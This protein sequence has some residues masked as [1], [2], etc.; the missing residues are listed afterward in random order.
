MSTFHVECLESL[1]RRGFLARAPEYRNA[2]DRLYIDLDDRVTRS[3]PESKDAFLAA[4]HALK[5]SKGS[6]NSTIRLKLLHLC[7][8]YFYSQGLLGAC[9]E[10]ARQHSELAE[11][12][13]SPADVRLSYNLRA[14]VHADLGDIAAALPLYQKA[15]EISRELG[16]ELAEC[17]V[18][19]NIGGTFNQ[20]GLHEEAIPCFRR[21]AKTAR[22]VNGIDLAKMALSNLSQSHYFLEDFDEGLKAIQ[23]CTAGQQD[24]TDA[25]ECLRQT[26]RQFMFVQIALELGHDR[27]AAERL[28]ACKNLA[29]RAGSLRATVLADVASGRYSVRA[30]MVDE[31][32][33]ILRSAL[34][35]SR[36]MDSCYRMALNATVKALDETQQLSD[37]LEHMVALMDH[38]RKRKSACLNA[39]LSLGTDSLIF[40]EHLPE[41]AK[42][43]KLEYQ[44]A[45]LRARTAELDSETSRRDLLERLAVTADLTEDNS[46]EHGYRVGRM[47][48]LIGRA[49]GFPTE[50]CESVELAA[51]LH[52]IGKLAV[53]ERIRGSS[54]ALRSGE[55]QFMRAHAVIGAE[56][57]GDS[58]IPQ[59]CLAQ[60]I[61]RH[62]HEWWDG[63]GYPDGLARD[64]IPMSA[65]IVAV[66]DVFDALTHG[67]PYA[68]TWTI[69]RALSEIGARKGTQFEPRLVDCFSVLIGCLCSQSA[70]LDG[71]LMQ[72]KQTSFLRTRKRISLLVNDARERDRAVTP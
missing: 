58:D 65:R 11:D 42:G 43:S 25:E 67:R 23:A 5:R 8:R 71:Y 16:D 63:S 31:G 18:L 20:S 46:G 36:E 62:H 60:E 53:P 6:G 41:K 13:R 61:A 2:L 49:L 69:D 33:A 57:L 68:E 72:G 59:M 44:L 55:R 19:N 17:I 1:A 26:I 51:R 7:W 40:A 3:L 28:V 66:A 64:K 29:A 39:L 56:M 54:Q 48:S 50:W 10:A 4:V 21:V 12:I 45:T 22:S 15:L 30:G 47:S 9:L 14:I 70:D 24:S 32:L 34:V 35:R 27:L 37:A 52:D 38:T